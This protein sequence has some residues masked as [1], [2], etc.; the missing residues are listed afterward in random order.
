[1]FIV[2]ACANGRPDKEYIPIFLE[3]RSSLIHSYAL[4]LSHSHRFVAHYEQ[5]FC[6]SAYQLEHL[7]I[8]HIS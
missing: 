4:Q 2:R 1:M 6:L 5:T 8:L 3:G 7:N